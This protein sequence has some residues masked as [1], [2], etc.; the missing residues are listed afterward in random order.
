MASWYSTLMPLSL[1]MGM[2]AVGA[3]RN[4]S[5]LHSTLLLFVK[6]MVWG[7]LRIHE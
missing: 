5:S 7:P 4:L 6:L 1:D 3:K 2:V